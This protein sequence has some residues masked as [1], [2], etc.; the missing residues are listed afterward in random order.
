M[1]NFTLFQN[2][3]L[4]TTIL[5]FMKMAEKFP[6]GWKTMWEKKK[7]Q[8]SKYKG[9]FGKGLTLSQRQILNYSKLKEFSDNNFKFNEKGRNLSKRV[10]NTAGKGEIAHHEQFLLFSLFF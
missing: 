9:L 3:S 5:S 6:K 2:E 8:A 10:E 7:L 4:Q 1:T